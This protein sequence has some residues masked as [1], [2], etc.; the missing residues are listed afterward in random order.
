MKRLMMLLSC[1]L[2]VFACNKGQKDVVGDI[3]PI[4]KPVITASIES[5]AT[6]LYLGSKDGD[7]NYE[8]KW[9]EGD[10][11]AVRV[12]WGSGVT[13]SGYDNSVWSLDNEDK[14]KVAGSFTPDEDID[15]K[16]YAYGAYFPTNSTWNI[17]GDGLFYCNYNH[18]YDSYTPGTFISPLLA[19]MNA[20]GAGVDRRV[21]NISFKHVGATVKVSLTNVPY[22]A[23]KIVLTIDNNYIS[24]S[25]WGAMAVSDA[26]SAAITIGESDSNKG[27]SITLEFGNYRSGDDDLDFFFPVP[28]LTTTPNIQ[29]DLYTFNTLIWTKTGK[30][31]TTV[32]RG[33]VLVMPS[34]EVETAK[35][36][37]L[38]SANGPW[39]NDTRNLYVYKNSTAIGVDFPGVWGM[40]TED[41]GYSDDYKRFILP[42]EADGQTCDF[43][44]SNGNSGTQVNLP[45]SAVA[46][47]TPLYFGT[48]GI[49]VISVADPTAPGTISTAKRIWAWS[50]DATSIGI[51][52]FDGTASGT[53]WDAVRAMTKT[54]AQI[55]GTY[56]YRYDI[57]SADQDKTTKM[58]FRVGYNGNA[59]SN[60]TQDIALITLSKS[61]Y[62]KTG[63]A[64]GEG[65]Y[66]VTSYNW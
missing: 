56:W 5:Q 48:N 24:T 4:D 46:V 12:Y 28:P 11:I 44:Y 41:L 57:P 54:T 34:I 19:N 9:S 42:I 29:I 36:Y 66:A 59:Y 15:E 47:G 35:V 55:N 14:D 1:S 20:D 23:N 43:I 6:K 52:T 45:Q 40:Y 21:G 58:V 64:D 30:A 37:V 7:D 32:S 49:E 38:D 26:G 60:Q 53:S 62:Y 17:G 39:G 61:F 51:H 31:K 3:L 33:E 50:P 10:K 25:S 18:T 13:E 2:A 65:K 22:E 63:D 16:N 8:M 27:H